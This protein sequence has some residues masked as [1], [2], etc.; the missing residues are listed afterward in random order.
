M[1]L[2]V[3]ICNGHA[4]SR[5]VN[6]DRIVNVVVDNISWWRSDLDRWANPN[7]NGRVIWDGKYERK[8]WRRGRR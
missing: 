2:P 7:R 4:V 8:Q 1:R 5:V 6:N 3:R